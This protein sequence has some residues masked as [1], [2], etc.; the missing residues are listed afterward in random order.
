[1]PYG[2][3]Y[4]FSSPGSAAV[5]ELTRVMAE[6]EAKKRQ[7]MLDEIMQRREA[8]TDEIQRSQLESVNEG[9]EAANEQRR[10]GMAVGLAGL[11]RPGQRV[12]AETTDRLAQGGLGILVNRGQQVA[13]QGDSETGGTMDIADTFAGTPAQ[14]K[15]QEDEARQAKYLASLDPNSPEARALNYETM[16]GKNAPASMF[17]KKETPRSGI[18]GEY[19]YAK[20]GGYTGSFQEYQN[21]DANRKRPSTNINMPS[22]TSTNRRVD[23]IVTQFTNSPITKKYNVVSDAVAFVSRLNPNTTSPADDQALIYAFAK[24]MDPDSVVREGEYATVGKYA[25]SWASK[26]GF[27]AQRVLSETQ[28]LTPRARQQLIATIKTRSAPIVQQYENWHDEAKRR[29]ERVDK[30]QVDMLPEF[31]KAGATAPTAP[32]TSTGARKMIRDATGKLVFAP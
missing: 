12:D 9:R 13:P 16:T 22:V 3:R 27:D 8:R 11:M 25:Q 15:A 7:A 21:E 10:Q 2:N 19:E 29:I 5:D 18:V 1:M 30:S 23:S 24:A 20:E 26:F 17:E 6:Q 31:Q 4:N 14:L 28:I 32:P